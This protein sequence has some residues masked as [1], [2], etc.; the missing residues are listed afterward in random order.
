MA[1]KKLDKLSVAVR[2]CALPKPYC[3]SATVTAS[4]MSAS[5]LERPEAVL[6]SW[7]KRENARLFK[8]DA[9]GAE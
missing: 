1:M 5:M 3:L 7:L 2:L 4:F 6:A 9:T 8:L